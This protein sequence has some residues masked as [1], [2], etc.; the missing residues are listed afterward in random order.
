M[1]PQGVIGFQ[2]DLHRGAFW[3]QFHYIAERCVAPCLAEKDGGRA[4]TAAAGAIALRSRKVCIDVLHRASCFHRYWRPWQQRGFRGGRF[5]GSLGEQS[6]RAPL[7]YFVAEFISPPKVCTFNF[8]EIMVSRK[9]Q[10]V[11]TQL[12]SLSCPVPRGF[13]G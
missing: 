4:F 13:K 2:N 11:L 10:S 12:L 8:V 3:L 6:L 9:V 1:D 7:L 5:L